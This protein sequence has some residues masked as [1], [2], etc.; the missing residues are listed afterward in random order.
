MATAT[1][2]GADRTGDARGRRWFEL[3][4]SRK[5]VSKG[6][7]SALHRAAARHHLDQSAEDAIQHLAFYDQLTGLSNRRLLIDRLRQALSASARS[8]KEGALLFLDLDNFK[9]LN[10]T[11]GHDFG[12]LL[13]Q[14]VAQRLRNCVRE[15]DTVARFG[16]DEF[17]VMLEDLSAEPIEAAEQTRHLQ[18]DLS[19]PQSALRP[20]RAR[21]PQQPE[22]RRHLVPQ[23]QEG[24]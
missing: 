15:R 6:R 11:L 13:L 18:Q 20:G 24:G 19:R 17:V 23:A 9:S 5:A 10:D 22:H 7:D 1:R 3:S 21:V 8:G 16:G 14:Q 2:R 4:A 12:D